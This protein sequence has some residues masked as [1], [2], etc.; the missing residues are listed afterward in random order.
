MKL[1]RKWS[2]LLLVVV[3]AQAAVAESFWDLIRPYQGPGQDIVTLVVT[4]NYKNPR[5]LADLIQ[6]ESRQPYILVP[7][8]Q[9]VNQDILYFCPVNSSKPALQIKKADFSRFVQF[10]NPQR[11]VILG[12]ANYVPVEYEKSIDPNI[13]VIVIRGDDWNRAA[14]G[15]SNL[16]NLSNLKSDYTTLSAKIKDQ[17]PLYIPDNKGTE[18]PVVAAPV[19]TATTPD[20]IANPDTGVTSTVEVETTVIEETVTTEK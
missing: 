18:M 13:P 9:D 15:L 11:V 16:L 2:V 4:A 5:L 20:V 8:K 3:V 1:L 17:T 19:S 7:A 10:V 12:D 14:A 6:N